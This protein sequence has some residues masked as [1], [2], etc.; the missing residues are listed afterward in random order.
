[1]TR[2]ERLL[3]QYEDAFFALLMEDVMVREVQRLEAWNRQLA[4]GPPVPESLDR[5]CQEAIRRYFSKERRRSAWRTTRKALRLAA[6]VMAV[7]ATLFTT[8][9]AVSEDFRTA[10]VNLA[11]TVT[12]KYIQWDIQRLP[13]GG[14]TADGGQ[15]DYFPN[16]AVGWVP[17]GFSYREGEFG[18]YAVF[19][20]GEGKSFRVTVYYGNA[21]VDFNRPGL[22]RIENVSVNGIHAT[23]LVGDNEK[24]LCVQYLN[25]NL[26]IR[27]QTTG[28]VS[29]EDARKIL[30]NAQ[31]VH[32]GPNG[33]GYFENVELRWLP[34][35][36]EYR[37]GFYDWFA[38]FETDSGA[39][40]WVYLYDGDS[41]LKIDTENAEEVEN[42]TINGNKG[43]CIVQDGSI[44]IVLS[45]LEHNL[46]F[47]VLASDALSEHT[48]Y[49]VMEHIA[50]VP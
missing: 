43:L 4:E 40:L 48:V 16:V 45:D 42:I 10:A 36:M 18:S 14:Q 27:V 20:N 33:T 9:F 7:A 21:Y 50:V 34:E 47:D 11:H 19:E 23:C 31:V 22:E 25:N 39:W 8:A 32:G 49:K 44:H 12:G 26:D 13:G 24:D 17:E 2:H 46:Y 15:L 29:L 28:G 3:E 30:E 1:M 38:K 6:V 5:R 35:G 37:S 41:S